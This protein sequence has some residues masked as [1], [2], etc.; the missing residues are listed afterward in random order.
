MAGGPACTQSVS[1]A[2]WKN[3]GPSKNNP[4]HAWLPRW[5]VR[6]TVTLLATWPGSLPFAPV[7]SPQADNP[8]PSPDLLLPCAQEKERNARRK[9]KKAPA[10]AS[11]ETAFPPVVEDEEME[12]SGVSGNEEEMVEEAEGEGWR[13]LAVA[14]RCGS[15]L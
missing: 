8:G 5:G 15:R 7:V 12:A 14:G 2:Q 4:W 6:G 1:G 9:K 11:E 10:A 3:K 13:S